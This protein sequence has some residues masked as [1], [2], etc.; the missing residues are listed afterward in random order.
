[1][2]N[3]IILSSCLFGSFFLLSKSLEFVNRSFL[4][5]KKIPHELLLINGVIIGTSGSIIIYS[6]AVMGL[7]SL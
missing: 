1:M 6:F 2:N 4:E 5:D 3:F 7:R